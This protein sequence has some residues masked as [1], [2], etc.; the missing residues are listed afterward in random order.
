M[1]VPIK[2]PKFLVDLGN[3]T[4]SGVL[5]QG[6]FHLENT[7]LRIIP[8][9]QATT[10]NC[11]QKSTAGVSNDSNKTTPIAIAIKTMATEPYNNSKRNRMSSILSREA[12]T[13]SRVLVTPRWPEDTPEPYRNAV[14]NISDPWRSEQQ[15]SSGDPLY[16]APFRAVAR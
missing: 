12:L 5:R 16:P 9:N 11:V 7:F 2:L 8:R 10:S 1:T 15:R 14:P 13:T 3:I 6:L 4:H